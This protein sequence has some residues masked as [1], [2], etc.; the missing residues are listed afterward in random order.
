[1]NSRETSLGGEQR[2]FPETLWEVVRRAGNRS[3]AERR[4]AL[5]ELGRL[6][7]KPVYCYFRLSWSRPNEECKDLVQGFFLWLFEGDALEKYDPTRGRFRAY[8]K[9]LLKH[10]VQHNDEALGR[11][12]RGGGVT[13]L[14]LDDGDRSLEAQLADPRFK[15]PDA[16]FDRSWRESILWQALQAVRKR[17]EARGKGMQLDIFEAYDLVP[18]P[19][20]PTYRRLAERYGVKETDVHNALDRMREE[21]RLQVREEL[22]RSA[23]EDIEDEWNE[24]LGS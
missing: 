19:E 10:F 24:F 21:I 6:Y 1:M 8:L 9:S 2:A 4:Q 20:R 23:S 12:K 15:D 11:I 18:P 16:A 17:L 3:D 13:V 7:W 14:P 22:S 5:E